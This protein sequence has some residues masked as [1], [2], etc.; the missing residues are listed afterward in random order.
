M[1]AGSG[2]YA[3]ST[4]ATYADTRIFSS[5]E[6]SVASVRIVPLTIEN[7]IDATDRAFIADSDGALVWP[8]AR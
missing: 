5:R 4:P 2:R 3:S 8:G 1:A 6:R 7:M